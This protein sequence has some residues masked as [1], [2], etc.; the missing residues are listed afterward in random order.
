MKR[1]GVFEFDA[2]TRRLRRDGVD[3]H[4]APKAFEL[5]GLLLE[6]SPR[7]V[8]KRELHARLW[9]GGTVAD[10]TLVA[11]VK[12]L[13]RALHDHD[14]RARLIRTVHRVGYALEGSRR[15]RPAAGAPQCWLAAG[16]RRMPLVAGENII[17]RDTAAQVRLEDAGVSR[18]HAR[19][20]VS[21]KGAQ[22][23]DLGSKNGTYLGGQRLE[24]VPAALRDGVQLVFGTVPVVYRESDRGMPTLTHFGDHVDT[25]PEAQVRRP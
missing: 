9:P 13:R 23:E 22:V 10:A 7:V 3:I 24:S 19:I 18:R 16:Q 8:A 11:L 14:R 5:L 15:E 25:A 17:G 6:A 4:L 12:Q 1:F 20:V 2:V 21:G